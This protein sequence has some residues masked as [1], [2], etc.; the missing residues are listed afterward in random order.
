[1]RNIENLEI[2]IDLAVVDADRKIL[3]KRSV[4]NLRKEIHIIRKKEDC[5]EQEINDF[6]EHVDLYAQ[7]WTTL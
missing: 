1:M 7:D 3:W 2:L 4:D 5:T 6:Q